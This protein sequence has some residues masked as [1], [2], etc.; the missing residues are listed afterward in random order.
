MLRQIFLEHPESVGETYLAHQRHAFA[1]GLSMIAGGL[2]CLVHGLV[3]SM[4]LHTGSE[5]ISRLHS[6]MAG[7]RPQA[8]EQADKPAVLATRV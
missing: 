4:F 7:R 2:A 8:D 5:T 1:F 6:R 3:P